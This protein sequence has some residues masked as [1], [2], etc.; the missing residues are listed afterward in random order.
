M[1]SGTPVTSF[2]LLGPGVEIKPVEGYP[3]GSYWNFNEIGSD[4]VVEVVDVGAEI[5]RGIA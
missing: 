3:L 5:R 2:I 4:G 1:F